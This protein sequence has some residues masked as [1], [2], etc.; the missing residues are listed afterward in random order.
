MVERPPRMRYIVGSNQGRVIHTTLKFEIPLPRLDF[1]IKW[2][3]YQLVQKVPVLC[4][5][6]SGKLVYVKIALSTH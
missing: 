2:T 5:W 6:V 4:D 3:E 1:E